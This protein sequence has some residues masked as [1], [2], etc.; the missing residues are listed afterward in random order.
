MSLHRRLLSGVSF[1]HSG[2]CVFC[3]FVCLVTVCVC[4]PC[5]LPVLFVCCLSLVVFVVGLLPPCAFCLF[6]CS[7]LPPASFV[8]FHCL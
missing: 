2:L 6:L 8:F 4:L 1:L 7:S 3:M 5:G